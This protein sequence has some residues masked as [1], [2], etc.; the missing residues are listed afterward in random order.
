MPRKVFYVAA[1]LPLLLGCDKKFGIDP[2]LV[3]PPEWVVIEKGYVPQA[4]KCLWYDDKAT[5]YTIA[6]DDAR[7]THFQVAGPALTERKMR[8]TFFIHTQYITDW[9][10]WQ[11]LV[12]A[13][14]EIG[15]HTWSHPK[16]TEVSEARQREELTRA[17]SDIRSG[18]KGVNKI[19]SFCYPFGLFNDQVRQ[20]VREF[21]MSARGGG[22][23]NPPDLSDEQL[24][25]VHG[26]GVYPP[27]DVADIAKWVEKAI[28]ERS[29]VM[30]YFHSVSAKGD[31]ANE[32]IPIARY[33]QHLDYIKGRQDSLWIA[34][35]GQVTAY[36]RLR[37]DASVQ[38]SQVDST[39]LLLALDHLQ[40]EYSDLAPLTVKLNLPHTWHD[41]SLLATRVNGST[42]AVKRIADGT[43]LI[44]LPRS[45]TIRLMARKDQ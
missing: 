1:L 19:P 9:S 39:A 20:V 15:S 29:W 41:K 21:H 25:L 24:S 31:S 28:A 36:I 44:N 17:I 35:M 8:G 10:G 38:I 37:R 7:P 27:F 22:G 32:I 14:H 2:K 3:M 4:E 5:A 34:T 43:V 33:L 45:G 26:I 18:L 11:S 6:F 12:D 13:G 42:E 40:G 16:L 23:L 30:V